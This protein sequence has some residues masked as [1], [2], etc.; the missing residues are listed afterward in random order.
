MGGD[1]RIRGLLMAEGRPIVKVISAPQTARPGS[2]ERD[3]V[4]V[5]EVA[6]FLVAFPQRYIAHGSFGRRSEGYLQ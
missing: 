1:G 4:A 5:R 6:Q 3:A 2:F